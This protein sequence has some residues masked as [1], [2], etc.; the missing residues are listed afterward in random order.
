MRI[1]VDGLV[2]AFGS[3]RAVDD[4][5]LKCEQGSFNTLLGP[6]GCGKTTTIRCIA[7]L[8]QPDEGEISIGSNVVYS[9]TEGI[10]VPS[11]LRGVGMVFQQY[12]IWPHMTVF[13]NVAFPLKVRKLP[14]KD[15]SEK[16]MDTLKLVKL[17][18]FEEISASVLSGGEQQRVALARALVFD[19]EVLLLD[20]PLSNLDQKLRVSMRHEMISLHERIRV[21]TLY[22]THNQLEA[23]S[24]SERLW[25]M[26][27]GKIVA[28]GTPMDL[29]KNPDNQFV[30]EFLGETNIFQ[31]KIR[32]GHESAQGFVETDF[33]ELVCDVPGEMYADGEEVFIG[34]KPADLE[35]LTDHPADRSNVFECGVHKSLFF[36][37]YY[38]TNCQLGDKMVRVQTKSSSGKDFL[39]G[40]DRGYVAFP[41]SSI[42]IIPKSQRV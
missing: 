27:E 34:I 42:I 4:I 37:Y 30:A 35:L 14:K 18:G 22:V 32:F 19:P 26:N 41:P 39:T 10:N 29:Y 6:S 40:S 11:E 23:L 25:I 21:T 13:E 16:V 36:G 28:S 20:E 5:S 7:G 31:G 33:G 3:K 38:E 24:L 8:E 17:D 2:K 12:A 15:I 1:I 9:N